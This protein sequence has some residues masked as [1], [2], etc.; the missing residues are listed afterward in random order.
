M[1]A[2]AVDGPAPSAPAPKAQPAAPDDPAKVAAARQ[3][4]QLYHPNTDPKNVSAM[5][6][7]YLPRAIEAERKQ[8]PKFDAKKFAEQRRAQITANAAK[9]L[10][11][12][13]HVVSRHFTLPELKGLIAFYSSPL[14]RKLTAETSKITMDLRQQRRQGEQMM[15]MKLTGDPKSGKVVL[16]PADP[17]KK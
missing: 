14:G 17:K 12:Q 13:S 9:S 1:A 15:K 11:L 5:I 6:D 16:T 2:P 8:D 10:D 4:I 7:R 3:F